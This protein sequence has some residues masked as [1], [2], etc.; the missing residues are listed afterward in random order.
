MIEWF[1]IK[2]H[3]TSNLSTTLEID[4]IDF[5]NVLFLLKKK[6]TWVNNVGEI[7]FK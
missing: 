7:S 1:V 4:R 5:K 2:Y 6:K 3:R